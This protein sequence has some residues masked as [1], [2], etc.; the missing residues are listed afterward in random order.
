MARGMDL[1]VKVFSH[2]LASS[3]S[4]SDDPFVEASR[5]NPG[6]LTQRVNS[7]IGGLGEENRKRR[8]KGRKRVNSTMTKK[9][10]NK[11]T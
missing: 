4:W 9:G 11:S 8:K 6:V 7:P 3:R 2:V 10:S 5:R 1:E